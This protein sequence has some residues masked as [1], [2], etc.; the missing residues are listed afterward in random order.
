M[1]P[2]VRSH[3]YLQCANLRF[4]EKG[5]AL[6]ANR[7]GY[8]DGIRHRDFRMVSFLFDQLVTEVDPAIRIAFYEELRSVILEHD[9][10]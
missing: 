7:D 10:D 8:R 9:H 2:E 1:S 6:C 4:E 3:A 5:K